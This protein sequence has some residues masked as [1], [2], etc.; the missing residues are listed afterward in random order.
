MFGSIL[1]WVFSGACMF[2]QCIDVSPKPGVGI[3][4]AALLNDMWLPGIF[5]E[6]KG[7]VQVNL[8]GE[9]C[10]IIEY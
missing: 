1:L 8:I 7:W 6:V 3:V 2:P 4:S 5:S 9:I 10:I